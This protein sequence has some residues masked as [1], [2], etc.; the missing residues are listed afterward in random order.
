MLKEQQGNGAA[1]RLTALIH[2]NPACHTTHTTNMTKP[3]NLRY[4]FLHARAQRECVD[5][6]AK[7]LLRM[8]KKSDFPLTERVSRGLK[9][10]R[11]VTL[12][13]CQFPDARPTP[14]PHPSVD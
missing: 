9:L 8:K 3:T 11:G 1:A 6:S 2:V 13:F 12:L 7:T 14:P 5:G 10:T 4:M